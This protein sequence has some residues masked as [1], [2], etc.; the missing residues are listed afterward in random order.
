MVGRFD[1]K[2][3]LPFSPVSWK[4]KK[5]LRFWSPLALDGYAAVSG[6]FLT[7]TLP[8]RSPF[9][10]AAHEQIAFTSTVIDSSIFSRGTGGNF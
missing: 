6:D 7:I 1:R 10:C 9:F 5:L 2:I 8:F 4:I 3:I